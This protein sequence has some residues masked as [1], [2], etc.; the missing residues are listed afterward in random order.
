MSAKSDLMVVILNNVLR[1]KLE[2]IYFPYDLSDEDSNTV[3]VH[4]YW[5]TEPVP[6]CEGEGSYTVSSNPGNMIPT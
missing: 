1:F 2:V 5:L 6:I 4:C 3:T